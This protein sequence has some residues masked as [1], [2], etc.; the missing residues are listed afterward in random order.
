MSEYGLKDVALQFEPVSLNYCISKLYLNSTNW[1]WIYS[2]PNC[3]QPETEFSIMKL[4]PFALKLYPLS[5]QDFQ[6]SV[7]SHSAATI[8]FH[9]LQFSFTLVRQI[10]GLRG[11]LIGHRR[12]A[13]LFTS[14]KILL[15][16]VF[17]DIPWRG[18]HKVYR[19]SSRL[20]VIWNCYFSVIRGVITGHTHLKNL[21][22]H[23]ISIYLF[24][25]TSAI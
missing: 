14:A 7:Y 16:S 20:R 15:H 17:L 8:Q 23:S 11:R 9:F 4:N 3:S 19:T 18:V 13:V 1:N 21:L 12:P 24:I 5:Y 22:Q 2:Q 10:S 25:P 6:L